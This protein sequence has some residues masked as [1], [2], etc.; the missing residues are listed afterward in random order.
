MRSKK[1]TFE[2]IKVID[3]EMLTPLEV[4]GVLGCAPY[5]INVMARK[6]P[7]QLRFPVI[8]IGKN[9]KIPRRAFVRYIE[10]TKGEEKSC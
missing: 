3:K 5:N 1:L 10:G 8:V 7:E 2:E 9:V 6:A 4:S